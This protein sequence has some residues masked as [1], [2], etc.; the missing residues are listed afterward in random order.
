[1][2]SLNQTG[3]T[4]ANGP[5]IRQKPGKEKNTG[6]IRMILWICKILMISGLINFFQD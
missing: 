3:L 2:V 4:A 6:I 1:V 5:D